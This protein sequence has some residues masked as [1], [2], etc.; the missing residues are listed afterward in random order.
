MPRRSGSQGR[1]ARAAAAACLAAFVAVGAF[2]LARLPRVYQDESLV[3]APGWYLFTT[4]RFAFPPDAGYAGMERHAFWFMPLHSILVGGVLAATG[5]GLLAARLVSLA[6]AALVL[7][8]AYAIGARLLSPAAGAAAVALLALAPVQA[9]LAHLPLGVPMADLA[10]LVRYDLP[11]GLFGLAA[12][13]VLAPSLARRRPPSRLVLA[14]AGGLV[15]L[16]TLCHANG[17]LFLPALFAAA[18]AAWGRPAWRVAGVPLVSGLALCLLPWALWVA[19]D[20]P[21]WRA[22]NLAYAARVDVLRPGFYAAN[23]AHEIDRY[24]LVIAAAR[25]SPTP[26]LFAAS[27]GAGA[28]FLLRRAHDDVRDGAAQALLTPLAVFALLLALLSRSKNVLYLAP[29]W[30]LAAL[31]AGFGASEAWRRLGRAGR[32]AVLLAAAAV[33]ADAGARGAAFAAQAR[34]A[35]AYADLTRRLAEALPPGSRVMGT[36]QWWLGVVSARPDY[37]T[38]PFHLTR[39]EFTRRPV[40]FAEAADARAPD[41]VVVD[42]VVRDFLRDNRAPGALFH[43]LAAEVEAWLEARTAPLATLADATYGPLEVRAVVPPGGSPSA[44]A[45]RP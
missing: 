17:L 9:P 28:V 29:L 18:R 22:Q 4:G 24:S 23:L 5:P 39:P 25:R 20:L 2:A 14:L 41:A 32:A 8:L 1:A 37:V 45:A 3:A 6:L 10:R 33:A 30:P 26:W 21:D 7:G 34:A 12:F 16:A 11:T 35:T 13:A 27:L 40:P 31:V 15:G 19:G 36:P 42:A 44:A 38:L 43:P